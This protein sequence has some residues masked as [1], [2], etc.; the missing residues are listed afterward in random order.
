MRS[1]SNGPTRL[2]IAPVTNHVRFVGNSIKK[3]LFSCGALHCSLYLVIKT[4][5][6]SARRPKPQKPKLTEKDIENQLSGVVVE[7][8]NTHSVNS[9]AISLTWKVRISGFFPSTAGAVIG[10]F[11]PGKNIKSCSFLIKFSEHQIF[12][13][14]LQKDCYFFPKY[15]KRAPSSICVK[16]PE[17][18]PSFTTDFF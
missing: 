17:N 9:S 6:L 10:I 3:T 13:P 8:V 18:I 16:N 2:E 15:K 7:M 5:H 1:T 14:F 11:P 4:I 12:F